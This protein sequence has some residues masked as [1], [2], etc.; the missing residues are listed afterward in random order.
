MIKQFVSGF[1]ITST[2]VTMPETALV[3]LFKPY[4]QVHSAELHVLAS[5][6]LTTAHLWSDAIF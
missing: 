3:F 6:Q 5:T 1:V 2:A 4:H